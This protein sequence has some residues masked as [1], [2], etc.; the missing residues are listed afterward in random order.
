MYSYT[1]S[2]VG[3]SIYEYVQ[4]AFHITRTCRET[5]AA[6]SK[7]VDEQIILKKYY[8]NRFVVGRDR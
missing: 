4:R 7:I 2:F 6:S 3:T 8:R 5:D 1:Y